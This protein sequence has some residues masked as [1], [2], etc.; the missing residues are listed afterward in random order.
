MRSQWRKAEPGS[1]GREHGKQRAIKCG[2]L[3]LSMPRESGLGF[4][5][6]GIKCSRVNR[7]RGLGNSVVPSQAREAFERLMGLK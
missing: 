1:Q 4:R 3:L 5:A 6:M 7:L 2:D